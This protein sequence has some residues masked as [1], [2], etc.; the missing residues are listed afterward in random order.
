MKPDPAEISRFVPSQFLGIE[1][2]SFADPWTAE[3]FVRHFTHPLS[4]TLAYSVSGQDELA[5]YALYSFTRRGFRLDN[6][7]IHPDY[8]RQG[9][10]EALVQILQD[11]LNKHRPCLF[12]YVRETNLA[13]QLFFRACGFQAKGIVKGRYQSTADDAYRMVYRLPRK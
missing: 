3:E 11:R 8:R 5:G 1:R 6:L 2:L 12:L 9:I 10:G 4:G 7:A 13:A